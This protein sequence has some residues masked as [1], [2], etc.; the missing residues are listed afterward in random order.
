[1]STYPYAQHTGTKRIGTPPLVFDTWTRNSYQ[2]SHPKAQLIPP[3]E[4]K[5]QGESKVRKIGPVIG[6]GAVVLNQVAG[7]MLTGSWPEPGEWLATSKDHGR[8]AQDEEVVKAWCITANIKPTDVYVA[9]AANAEPTGL[10]DAQAILPPGYALVSGGARAYLQDA[11]L[12]LSYELLGSLLV[13]SIPVERPDGWYAAATDHGT[14][15]PVSVEAY[16]VGIR[17]D[18]LGAHKLRGNVGLPSSST[19]PS[20]TPHAHGDPITGARDG[21]LTGGG[22]IPEHTHHTY[23]IRTYPEDEN[24][25]NARYWEAESTDHGQPVQAILTAW[26]VAIVTD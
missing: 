13:A 24:C 11:P 20:H 2:E 14:Q 26:A 7:N 12:H 23:L 3:K 6:G 17:N 18:V 1:M 5:D 19:T 8:N 25:A 15:S 4:W 16:A 21:V 22:G 10:V 9:R